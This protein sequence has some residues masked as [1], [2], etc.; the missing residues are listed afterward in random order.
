MKLKVALFLAPGNSVATGQH[1][2]TEFFSCGTLPASCMQT[3]PKSPFLCIYSFNWKFWWCASD[4]SVCIVYLRPC[5]AQFN[6]RNCA[7][8]NTSPTSFQGSFRGNLCKKRQ[9][10]MIPQ[11]QSGSHK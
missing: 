8:L 6:L 10:K 11:H 5:L 9:H 2:D 4:A 1:P 3:S 7:K